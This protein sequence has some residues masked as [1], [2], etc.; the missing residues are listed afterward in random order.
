M[1]KIVI[2]MFYIRIISWQGPHV[3]SGQVAT[4]DDLRS[5]EL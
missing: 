5:E 4:L 2:L 3:A 1:S